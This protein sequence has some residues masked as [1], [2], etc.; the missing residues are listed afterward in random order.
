M[1]DWQCQRGN[2]EAG[3]CVETREDG[4]FPDG[5]AGGG[6]AAFLVPRHQAP[7]AEGA[8]GVDGARR[9]VFHVQASEPGVLDRGL[10]ATGVRS[11]EQNCAGLEE[12]FP[13]A[14]RSWRAQKARAS[15]SNFARSGVPCFP[16]FRASTAE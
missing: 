3:F 8:G 11:V 13:A 5:R 6:R 14:H 4:G 7:F 15:S 1:Q 9:A 16:Y 10:G 2:Q 12:A